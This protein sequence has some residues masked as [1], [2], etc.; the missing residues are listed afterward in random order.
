[1]IFPS[2]TVKCILLS[3]GHVELGVVRLIVRVP[4]VSLND[5]IV[6]QLDIKTPHRIAIHWS[7]L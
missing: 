5:T 7:P 1:M 3:G 2:S 4:F 6:K